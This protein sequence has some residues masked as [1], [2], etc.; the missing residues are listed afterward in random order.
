[1]QRLGLNQGR[2]L[3]EGIDIGPALRRIEAAAAEHGWAAE[4]FSLPD[5]SG[6]S[7]AEL[8]AWSRSPKQPRKR[9]YLSAGIHGDEPAGTLALERLLAENLWPDDLELVLCPCLNRSGFG[10]NTRENAE[11]LDL[12]RDYR[13]P[14]T[15][16]VRNHV[17]WLDR[18][19][20]FDLALCLHE[21]WE[22]NGFYL[23]ELN[24][25]GRPSL[26]ERMVTA[27]AAVCPV[28]ASAEIDGRPTA[29]PG[30][31]RPDVDPATRADWPEAFYLIQ[32]KT[33][34]SYTL[35][36]PSDWPLSLRTDVLM[37]AVRAAL[38]GI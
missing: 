37:R 33:R 30:I 19:P 10:R 18:Q 7:T 32:H 8:L 28:D 13:E 2:Y 4:R 36:A 12:N 17:A 5:L 9:V 14:V 3:G 22:A 6:N 15:A 26:A 1:V 16:E 27:A 31:I 24:P 11:G 20:A 29:A 38:E 21:D 35:E 34:W 25:D 23:Y